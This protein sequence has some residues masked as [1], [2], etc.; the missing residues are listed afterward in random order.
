MRGIWKSVHADEPVVYL[1]EVYP[2]EGGMCLPLS[3]FTRCLPGFHISILGLI[4]L[5][6]IAGLIVKA[7]VRSSFFATAG[8]TA[9][10]A[11]LSP[12]Q[13]NEKKKEIAVVL[14][15]PE[16]FYPKVI[17]I[18]QKKFALAINNR[19]GVSELTLGLFRGKTQKQ[20]EKVLKREFMTEY[21][22]LNLSSGEYELRD[23]TRPEW[24]LRLIPAEK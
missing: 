15:S 6:G 4:L 1:P 3:T 20:A 17:T 2:P 24:V 10:M 16:G 8:K 11:A 12:S 23:L 19:T 13:N 22:E 7:G 9:S 18:P 21:L 14:L 5:A